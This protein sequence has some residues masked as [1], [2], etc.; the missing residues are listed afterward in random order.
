MDKTHRRKPKMKKTIDWIKHHQV[1]AFYLLALSISWGL[2]FAYDACV[3]RE[4]YLLLPIAFIG[5][6]GPGLAGIII[7]ALTNTQQKQ[8]SRKA[9]WIA[10]LVAWFVS[11]LVS[12]AN[13]KFIEHT[14]LSVV[15]IGL[16]TISVVPVA[17]V[18]ASAYSRNLAVR[19]YLS[20]LV[21]LR[22]VWGWSFVALLLIP[23]LFLIS[24]PLDTFIGKQFNLSIQFPEISFSLLGLI[25]IK[26]FY[27][28]F[29]FNATGEETGWRGFALPRLQART[30]P[31]LASLIIGF[32]WAS[33]HFPYWRSDG[34]PV[35]K[36][37]FWIEMWIGHIL[38]SFLIG[39]MYN[40]SKGSILVAGIVHAAMNTYQAFAPFSNSLFLIL[41]AAALVVILG[42]R[43][44]KKLPSNHPAVYQELN[45][46]HLEKENK[47]EILE[48]SHV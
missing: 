3:N 32:I 34:R 5:I 44:W 26:F 47:K 9:F 4:Q 25:A 31:L 13:L 29:F 20:S 45:S 28:F 10:F 42:D 43:M 2:E 37:E 35:L 1:I 33:W 17:F 8:G 41:S 14:Q 19:N 39:W 27:Q 24:V 6:C 46:I 38:A 11:S 18:I 12:I 30:S 15:V 23:V 22:G 48:V 7:S 40:R 36:M 21:R 16:F